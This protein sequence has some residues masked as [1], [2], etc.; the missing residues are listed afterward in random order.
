MRNKDFYDENGYLV[1]NDAISAFDLENFNKKY[2]NKYPNSSNKF[3][4][5]E[6]PYVYA[7]I[8]ELMEILCNS[9][10]FEIFD[11]LEMEVALHASSATVVST[12]VGWHQ[13]CQVGSSVAGNNYIGVWVAIE[14]IQPESGPFQ[15]IPKSHKWDVPFSEIYPKTKLTEVSSCYEYFE[16]KI[17]TEK[18]EIFTF[19]PKCGDILFWHGHMVHRGSIP[20][21]KSL[22]RKSLIGHYCNLRIDAPNAT[23]DEP[24]LDGTPYGLKNIFGEWGKGKYFTTK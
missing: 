11:E 4:V 15:L 23:G 24:A 16:H 9:F 14:D 8:P 1:I 2:L 5:L 18:P 13:D 22:T 12:E 6:S 3:N 10:I 20:E 7:E 21:Q 17:E 19:T